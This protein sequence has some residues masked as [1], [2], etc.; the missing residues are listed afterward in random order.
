MKL[1][2]Q[3]TKNSSFLATVPSYLQISSKEIV[4]LH[5]ADELAANVVDGQNWLDAYLH[6]DVEQLQQM[7]QHHVHLLNVDTQVREPLA[8]CRRKDNPNLCKADFPRMKWLVT[9]AVILCANLLRQMEQKPSGRRCMLGAMHGPMNHPCVNGTHPAMLACQRCNSDVQLPYRFPII[10]ETHFCNDASCLHNDDKVLIR[11]AQTAQDAQAGYACDYCTKR[12]PCAFNEA[13]ECSKG[14][15]NLSEKLRTCGD[16]VNYIGK[17][18]ATRLMNDAYGRGIV[19]G[20]VENMNLRAYHQPSR[21][22]AAEAIMTCRTSRFAG[23]EYVNM[24]QRMTDQVLPDNATVIAEVDTRHRKF[25]KI[26]LRD[27]AILYGQRPR[28][29]I[30]GSTAPVWYLSLDEFVKDWDTSW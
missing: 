12:Q 29:C 7:K 9:K 23:V 27:S 6:K 10:K 22:T 8:A 2:G 11:A 28:V 16:C 1:R 21:V 18:H 3:N 30:D 5:D 15:T 14:H 19:R 24:V 4:N 17:R 20:Q 26:T 25:R 13:K